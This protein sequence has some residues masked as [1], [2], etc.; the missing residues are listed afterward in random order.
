M[1]T[2]NNRN[3]ILVTETAFNICTEFVKQLSIEGSIL[4]AG[5]NLSDGFSS[6]QLQ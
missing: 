4:R 2:K 5:V 1:K 3:I 6:R